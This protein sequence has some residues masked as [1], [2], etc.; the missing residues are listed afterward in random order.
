MITVGMATKFAVSNEYS[1]SR[2]KSVALF[3][4]DFK[5]LRRWQSTAGETAL[6]CHRLCSLDPLVH[7]VIS[8]WHRGDAVCLKEWFNKVV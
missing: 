5:D 3:R 1:Q 2:H 6:N 8:A 4:F 7:I